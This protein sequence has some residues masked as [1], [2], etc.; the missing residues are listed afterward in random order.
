M[1]YV[2]P[3]KV[4]ITVGWVSYTFMTVAIVLSNTSY[5]TVMI[6]DYQ[7]QILLHFGSTAKTKPCEYHFN[8]LT[9]ILQ[10]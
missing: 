5:N 4:A 10:L 9:Q 7:L 3:L 6:I 1:Q 8:L 2:G